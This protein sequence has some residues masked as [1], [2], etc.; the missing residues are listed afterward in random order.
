MLKEK[1][2]TLYEK[3]LDWDGDARDG[4]FNYDDMLLCP[5]NI[6]ALQSLIMKKFNSQSVLKSRFIHN[7]IWKCISKFDHHYSPVCVHS[8][9][10]VIGLLECVKIFKFHHFNYVIQVIFDTDN[11]SQ[12]VT[13]LLVAVNRY[14]IREKQL[15]QNA[16]ELLLAILTLTPNQNENIIIQAMISAPNTELI[17]EALKL[18]CLERAD[19]IEQIGQIRWLS[20]VGLLMQF[21]ADEERNQLKDYLFGREIESL[22]ESILSLTL[23]LFSLICTGKSLNGSDADLSVQNTNQSSPAVSPLSPVVEGITGLIGRIIPVFAPPS[24]DY[25]DASVGS[26]SDLYP[27]LYLLNSQ[28]LRNPAI[29]K[30]ED[31]ADNVSN[32]QQFIF[33]CEE[34]DKFLYLFYT[35]KM[36]LLRGKCLIFAN[37]VDRGYK[38]KLFLEQFSIKSGVLNAELPENSK[39]NVIKQFNRGAFDYL[40]ATEEIAAQSTK[41]IDAEKSQLAHESSVSRGIDFKNV[42]CVC[43]LDLPQSV[44]NYTHRIGRTGRGNS[45]GVALSFITS[46][47][48]RVLKKIEYKFKGLIHEFK[49]LDRK[50][51]ENFRYRCDDVMKQVKKKSAVKD[52]RFKELKGELLNNEKLKAHFKENPTDLNAIRHDKPLNVLKA[53]PQLKHVPEYL[54]PSSLGKRT[55]PMSKHEIDKIEFKKRRG[56]GRPSKKAKI[57][58]LK[59]LKFKRKSKAA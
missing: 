46:S 40:I 22:N 33:E 21:R 30:L 24:V 1:V 39:L 19:Q 2:V 15:Y 18:I 7:F 9:Q 38:L 25:K 13:Q 11:L 42:A 14:I 48:H 36:K 6:E 53:Q 43:N 52:A 23:G 8:V 51:A 55:A 32:I 3:L 27:R 29:I 41:K 26:T 10:T 12:E 50:D 20:L 4:D 44:K 34:S 37:G 17:V 58:P 5:P 31:G 56:G 16:A 47:D 49:Q 57:D 59:S 54:M 28:L 45:R 35:L